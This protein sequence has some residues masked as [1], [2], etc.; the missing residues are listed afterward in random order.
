MGVYIGYILSLEETIT[1]P[2]SHLYAALIFSN[3]T[4]LKDK[5]GGKLEEI[6]EKKINCQR[7]HNRKQV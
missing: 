2:T 1:K 5:K 3:K 7:A 4:Y 6:K